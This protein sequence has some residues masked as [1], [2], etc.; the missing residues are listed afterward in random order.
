MWHAADIADKIRHAKGYKFTGPGIGEP[1]FDWKSFKPQRDAYIRRLNGIYDNMV[2][3]DGVD[4]HHGT[5]KLV[6]PKEVEISQDGKKYILHT[7]RICVATGGRPTIPSESDIP[8]A[9]L[10]INSDG[11]FD[12]ED[13]P[14]RVAVVGAGYIAVELAGVLNTL[15]SEVHLIIRQDNFLR[16]FDPTLYETLG[17]WAEHTG[18]KIHK[19][20]KVTKVEGERGQTL[21][22]H[23][24]KGETFDVDT[25]IW[26]IG[27]H[28]NTEGLGL[29]EL[30]VELNK[31]G[32]IVTNEYQESN[33][34]GILAIGDVQG[35]ALLTPSTLR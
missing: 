28:A 5:A 2:T 29:E 12:L 23:T 22:V 30:G 1:H 27:R 26:A 20:S 25:L 35:R 16:T 6:S 19:R 7:D 17:P 9:S 24:D 33:V 14:R 13:Q 10:G 4:Y 31:K 3:K 18:I 21:T 15:G 32:D 34:P 11:F 8:G